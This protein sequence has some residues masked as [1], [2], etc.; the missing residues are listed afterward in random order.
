[1]DS[2]RENG[3][4][5]FKSL[6]I[7]GGLSKNPVFIQ[8]HA[9]ACNLPVLVSNETETVLI[10]AA[11]LGA[12]GAKYFKNLETA[13][14]EMGGTGRVVQPH[15]DLRSYHERK[16]RIFREMLKDQLKYRNIMNSN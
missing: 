10:G 2:L 8:A 11:M 3:R 4:N 16:Y 7:C 5:P 12:C 13:S 14:K 1:M 9:E 6:L 15:D